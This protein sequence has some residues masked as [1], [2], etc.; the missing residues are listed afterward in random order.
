M[1]GSASSETALR[2]RSRQADIEQLKSPI[3]AFYEHG[4]RADIVGLCQA[5]AY[6]LNRCDI[7]LKRQDIQMKRLLFAVLAL[8]S[9]MQADV[10][11]SYT[12]QEAGNLGFTYWHD[13]PT[14]PT[15]NDFG[16]PR[17]TILGEQ[18][19]SCSPG[20]SGLYCAEADFL[21]VTNGLY[22]VLS[23]QSRDPFEAFP[24]D[25]VLFPDGKLDLP[26]TYYSVLG[27]MYSLKVSNDPRD[28]A[29]EPAS[30]VLLA[31]GV[32]A[33]AL[34]AKRFDPA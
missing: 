22:V 30:W 16:I 17:F 27:P 7:L 13:G 5:F 21:V 20:S 32:L 8:S 31:L 2:S 25:Q 14:V 18:L 23:R 15:I 19:H 10:I 1:S 9:V 12:F 6:L 11:W 4:S 33:V 26:G 29:P 34:R 3:D 28:L 24:A